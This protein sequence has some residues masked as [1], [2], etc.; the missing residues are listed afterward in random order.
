M[1]VVRISQGVV[2]ATRLADAEA[3]L[4]ASEAAL[5]SPIQDLPGLLHYYVGVDRER[6]YVTNVSVWRTLADAHR[7][8][9]L[10]AMLDQRPILEAAGVTFAPITNHEVLWDITP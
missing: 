10:Q 8:D 6:G 7:M 1:A 5:R 3:Q 9:T 4:A 2:D